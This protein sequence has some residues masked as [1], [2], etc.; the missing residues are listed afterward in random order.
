MYLPAT[1]FLFQIISSDNSCN[2]EIFGNLL[3]PVIRVLYATLVLFVFIF[4]NYKYFLI[5][6][7]GNILAKT[8]MELLYLVVL[9]FREQ[10]VVRLMCIIVTTIKLEYMW[11]KVTV[12]NLFCS[13]ITQ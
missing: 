6:C 13:C 10:L 7:V 4:I 8:E 11:V 12:T 3:R 1:K 9:Q 2:F 5:F